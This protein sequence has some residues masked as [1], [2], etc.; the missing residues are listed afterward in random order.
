MKISL[1]SSF[2]QPDLLSF[3]THLVP[4]NVRFRL[5]KRGKWVV[6]SDSGGLSQYLHW[7]NSWEMNSMG[8]IFC[9][10]DKTVPVETFVSLR[11]K[12]LYEKWLEVVQGTH[13]FQYDSKLFCHLEVIW[14]LDDR[15]CFEYKNFVV[16]YSFVEWFYLFFNLSFLLFGIWWYNLF[17]TLFN[18]F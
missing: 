17:L 9:S 8:F 6:K 13:Y 11:P 16:Y 18:F 7:Y 2:N 10:D 3:I 14:N 12:T 15:N 4:L 5:P 1:I